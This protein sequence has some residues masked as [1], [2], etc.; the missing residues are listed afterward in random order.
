MN[1]LSA[2]VL[3]NHRRLSHKVRTAS[4]CAIAGLILTV[5]AFALG[6]LFMHW[7][8]SQPDYAYGVVSNTV[9]VPK[10]NNVIAV[11]KT[12]LKSDYVMD[13]STPLTSEKGRWLFAHGERVGT[14]APQVLVTLN[15]TTLPVI[16]ELLSTP[17]SRWLSELAEEK[18]IALFSA[19]AMLIFAGYLFRGTYILV[20]SLGTVVPLWHLLYFAQWNGL[21]S[22]SDTAFYIIIA[23]YLAAFIPLIHRHKHYRFVESF[24]SAVVW[25]FTL[26]TIQ[27]WL[28][29]ED[30]WV[31]V[32]YII[33]LLSPASIAALVSAY[34]FSQAMEASLTASYGLIALCVFV[35]V[36]QSVSRG[37]L[38]KKVRTYI[39]SLKQKNNAFP[40]GRVTLAQLLKQ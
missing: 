32:I 17:P 12:P 1:T 9:G 35:I 13:E 11:L 33:A 39:R 37:S 14:D 38:R 6:S 27:P 16:G 30:V 26:S 20:L 2:T 28:G 18:H 8:S 4:P 36:A 31:L 24:V 19:V 5:T 21:L 25:Y 3:V 22:L 29:W 34:L 7:L 15:H 10:N 40:K 23:L